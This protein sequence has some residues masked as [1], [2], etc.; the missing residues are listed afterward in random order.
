M[1]FSATPLPLNPFLPLPPAHTASSGLGF[2][3]WPEFPSPATALDSPTSP[4][5]Q[6]PSWA[7]V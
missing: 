4:M 6:H 5:R 1:P 7:G 3:S 2:L